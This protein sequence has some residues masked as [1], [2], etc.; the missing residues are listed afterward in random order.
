[1]KKKVF[2]FLF[3]VLTLGVCFAQTAANERRII[4]TWIDHNKQTWTFNANGNLTYKGVGLKFGAT[5]TQLAI[6]EDDSELAV[7]DYSISSDGNTLIF[8]RKMDETEILP[9]DSCIWLTKK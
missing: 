5:G 1:M 9:G 2:V 4:G 7:Y 3:F 6:L 8:N